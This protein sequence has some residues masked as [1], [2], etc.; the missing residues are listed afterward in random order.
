MPPHMQQLDKS[1]SSEPDP[2]LEEYRLLDRRSRIHQYARKLSYCERKLKQVQQ[3]IAQG[4]GQG[5][6]ERYR[7]WIPI[8]RGFSSPVSYMV[9]AALSIHQRNHHFL[10]Q[11]EHHTAL[12][13][14]YLGAVEL[15][16]CLPLWP[17]E[18][19]HPLEED[20][21]IRTGGL[22]EIANEAG[23]VHGN[24][25]GCD[26][27]YIASLDIMT[28]VR[29][30][31]KVHHL[32]VS[33][34]PEAIFLGNHRAR[35]RAR[36]NEMYCSTVGAKHLNESGK[37]FNRTLIRN[38]EAYRPSK[39]EI[40]FWS[41]KSQL[42]DFC[43]I[44]NE[45][46]DGHPLSLTITNAGHEVGVSKVHASSLWRTGMWLRMIDIDMSTRIS[47][48]KPIKRGRDMCLSALCTHFLGLKA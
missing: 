22:L 9:F 4:R 33:C 38:L 24:F 47:M 16:E 34:K 23:I 7:P 6:R 42:L 18:H 46:D 17:N 31:G 48:L 44:L 10:S 37:Q 28:S 5:R 29:W 43:G 19:Q 3:W 20:V 40:H 1:K 36:L 39:P 15:R 12:Q 45:A 35:E 14:A 8:S 11:L 13:L 26:V 30:K 25:V 21:K 32:G 27:P 41:D 2:Y